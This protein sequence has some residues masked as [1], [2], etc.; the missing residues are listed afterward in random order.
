MRWVLF[1]KRR[2]MKRERKSFRYAYIIILALLS[3]QVINVQDALK[4]ILDNAYISQEVNF[5]YAPFGMGREAL[6]KRFE[7]LTEHR[8]R[9]KGD[10]TM[11]L[12]SGT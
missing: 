7:T 3:V 9:H 6:A 4:Y 2:I 11:E 1:I 12:G 5:A 10:L 8:R